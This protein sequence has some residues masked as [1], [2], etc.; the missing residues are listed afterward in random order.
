LAAGVNKYSFRFGCVHPNDDE[1]GFGRHRFDVTPEAAVRGCS[2]QDSNDMGLDP[3]L[4]SSG[5]SAACMACFW[6]MF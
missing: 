6:P 5:P 2:V 3:S 4:E 1:A